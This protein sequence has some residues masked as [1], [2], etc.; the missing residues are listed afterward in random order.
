M[1]IFFLLFLS[2]LSVSISAQEDFERYIDTET[3]QYM[4]GDSSLYKSMSLFYESTLKAKQHDY[5]NAQTLSDSALI[6]C[7]KEGINAVA[8]LPG[9]LYASGYYRIKNKNY[10][11]GRGIASYGLKIWWN[12]IQND[13]LSYMYKPIRDGMV[14]ILGLTKN[15]GEQENDSINYSVSFIKSES[16]RI[17]LR[18]TEK[19]DSL[20]MLSN[21][22][23]VC[24]EEFEANLLDF[25]FVT[26]IGHRDDPKLTLSTTYPYL[27]LIAKKNKSEHSKMYCQILEAMLMSC[28]KYETKNE[29]LPIYRMYVNDNSIEKKYQNKLAELYEGKKAE[30][31]ES[32]NTLTENIDPLEDQRQMDIFNTRV[33]RVIARATATLAF[34]SNDTKE[35]MKCDSLIQSSLQSLSKYQDLQT[36]KESVRLLTE[37]SCF[38]IRYYKE[39]GLSIA[40]AANT[41]GEVFPFLNKCFN[42]QVSKEH[43]ALFYA[44]MHLMA[45]AKKWDQVVNIGEKLKEL[46]KVWDKLPTV[47]HPEKSENVC[48]DRYNYPIAIP[49]LTD[50]NNLLA[51]GYL[52]YQGEKDFIKV[53]ETFTSFLRDSKQKIIKDVKSNKFLFNSINVLLR[54]SVYL[55]QQLESDLLKA[56]A[57]E[58]AILLKGLKYY[59]G[60]LVKLMVKQGDNSTDN[61][62]YERYTKLNSLIL[63][64]SQE[65][66]EYT[67][68]ITK[69]LKIAELL[70]YTNSSKYGDF[71]KS[72]SS[73]IDDI[74]KQLPEK[75]CLVEFVEYTE[76]KQINLVAL[77]KVKGYNNII[78]VNLGTIEV[79]QD[80]TKLYSGSFLYQSFWEPIISKLPSSIS[81]IYFSPIGVVNTIGIE[82]AKDS[83]GRNLSDK[84]R[85][86]RLTN[87]REIFNKQNNRKKFEHIALF[88]DIDYGGSDGDVEKSQSQFREM[89]LSKVREAL[90][91]GSIK[92]IE[93]LEGTK[94][95]LKN[96]SNILGGISISYTEY[97]GKDASEENLFS[98]SNTNISQLHIATHGYFVGTIDAKNNTSLDDSG[99]LFAGAENTLIGDEDL[100]KT[101]YKDGVLKASEIATMSF[102]NLDLVTL[103]ACET[104]LG[105]ISSEGVFGLQRGFKIA[106]ANS[107]LMSLWKVDDAATCKLMTE[108]YSNWIGK[109]MTKHDA[110]E[111]AKKTVR[112]TKGW[113]DPK[114]WAAFI[115]LDALD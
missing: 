93:P 94:V 111:T 110:L 85:I 11:E 4:Q 9:F 89:S 22:D 65:N 70:L 49:P 75:S 113:E 115:L 45:D 103:S 69:E 108:F 60:N 78:D 2:V 52:N 6:V 38:R 67:D 15:E 106:G 96:I 55:S 1:R 12:T 112:E 95:E 23:G 83:S 16:L 105:H 63:E 77:L 17:W 57:F 50:V 62:T 81:C 98:L 37:L 79:P 36:L 107:I 47:K 32:D 76:N 56:T 64:D 3:L 92:G 58:N 88:G 30:H 48:G 39:M 74:D 40:E 34:L 84:Y 66:K 109:K 14:S 42:N 53:E 59:S 35:L 73:T 104:A 13:K 31:S 114:Y 10:S 87:S 99:L 8:T 82:N 18:A 100:K 72:L 33:N 44:D 61:D 28:A 86:Y 19:M 26:G 7:P 29:A 102:P 20:G 80:V 46:Y 25:V 101:S 43:A 68:S 27:Q 71:I 97:S 91:R 24:S 21:N 51:K 41:F 54:N 90:K 5:V